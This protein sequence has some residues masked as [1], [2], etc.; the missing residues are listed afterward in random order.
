ML[1]Q[2]EVPL[3]ETCLEFLQLFS[4]RRIADSGLNRVY[5]RHNLAHE[6][7]YMMMIIS[8]ILNDARPTRENN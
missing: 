3:V 5:F 6:K 1:R 8:A 2:V 7:C 4:L